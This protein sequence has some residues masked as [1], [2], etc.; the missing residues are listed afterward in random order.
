MVCGFIYGGFG[1][2]S[3][4]K[5]EPDHSWRCELG[6]EIGEVGCPFGATLGKLGNGL[7]IAIIADA[8]MTTPCETAGDIAAHASKSNDSDIHEIA[9]L[10][11]SPSTSVSNLA[12]AN[13]G[14]DVSSA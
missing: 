11:A 6:D 7:R 5:H 8:A 13:N 14:P 9:T 10:S 2:R 1:D 4:R 3:H 12:I